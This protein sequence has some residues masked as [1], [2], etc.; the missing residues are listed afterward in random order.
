MIKKCEKDCK[1]VYIVRQSIDVIYHSTVLMCIKK[2]FTDFLFI[3]LRICCY[4]LRWWNFL[5]YQ[6]TYSVELIENF[7]IQQYVDPK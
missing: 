7:I 6:H 5:F 1:G 4:L 3:I 2:Y